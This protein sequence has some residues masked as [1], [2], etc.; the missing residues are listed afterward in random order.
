VRPGGFS[1]TE[2]GLSVCG[3][4]GGAR[5]LDVGCGTGASV[6]FLRRD[7]GFAAVGVD[8]S[9]SLFPVAG[10]AAGLPVAIACAEALPF[11]DGCCDGVLCECVLS[12]VKE[13]KRAIREF[14]R[15]LRPGGCM[16]LSDVYER[17]S[18]SGHGET[19]ADTDGR[20]GQLQSMAFV[21]RLLEDAGFETLLWEDHTRHLKELA[22]Q[23]ILCGD[24]GAGLRELCGYFASGFSC[25][26]AS[27][28]VLPGYY[29]LV[30]RKPTKG[31][32]VDE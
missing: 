27:R 26:P 19:G 22:A 13:P 12:L 30:A 4:G 29:M 7:H 15:V 11:S 10:D 6:D 2:R 5:L 1:L 9:G 32:V 17:L 16:I 31:E 20:N 25:A 18:D 21:E 3:F 14:S 23:L 28:T 24:D 8:M